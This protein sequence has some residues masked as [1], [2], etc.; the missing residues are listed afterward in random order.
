MFF[1]YSTVT[2]AR[3]MGWMN[4]IESSDDSNAHAVGE[5]GRLDPAY[6]MSERVRAQTNAVASGASKLEA[7]FEKV[8][9]SSSL[10]SPH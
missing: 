3:E 9:S 4:D 6:Q 1:V 7:V 10:R 8:C 2:S 5:L